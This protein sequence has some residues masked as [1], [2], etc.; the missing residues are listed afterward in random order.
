MADD[1]QTLNN[2]GQ[3]LKDKGKLCISVPSHMWL[4]CK[5]D[6]LSQHFRRYELSGLRKLVEEAGFEVLFAQNRCLF[7]TPI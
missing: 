7:V 2:V 1:K 5:E 4:W 3:I 6:E